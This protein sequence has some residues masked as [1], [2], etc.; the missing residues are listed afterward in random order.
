MKTFPIVLTSILLL[1]MGGV[2]ADPDKRNTVINKR[3]ARQQDRIQQ[4]VKSGELT[5][6]E[7]KE[8]VQE[9]RDI[10]KI[11]KIYKADGTLTTRERQDLQR[12][13]DQ[14]S[15]EIKAQKHDAQKR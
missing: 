11:E 5:K 7:T 6:K 3:E 14:S 13:L 4:G 8:A 9:Q 12:E 2:S 15:Q 10:K 1:A